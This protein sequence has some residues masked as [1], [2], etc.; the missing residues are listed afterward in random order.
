MSKTFTRVC[1]L[2]FVVMLT[3]AISRADTVVITSGF[4]SVTGLSGSPV[5]I[6]AGTNFS[7]T[8]SG[9]DFGFTGPEISCFPC[10]SGALIN[11]NGNYVG[12][13][14][15]QGTVALNGQT[16]NN[17]FI[18]GILTF[19]GSPVIV[20]VTN[21]SVTLFAPFTL[22]GSL[23]GCLESHLICQ[24][25]VF[26]TQVTGSGIASI[27]LQAFTDAQ[28]QTLFFFRNVTY[29]FDNTAIPEPASIL[30]LTTGLAA[31]GVAKRKRR[32]G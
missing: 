19:T 20:P 29:T 30:I 18:S 2:L 28:G 9:S 3:P 13:T 12:V 26:S 6:F 15:G 21:S 24:T 8:G 1:L 25:I 14:L 27:Q 22:D 16:F 11:T 17:I 23:N 7:A 10:A 5:Y 32:T 31:F 4:F